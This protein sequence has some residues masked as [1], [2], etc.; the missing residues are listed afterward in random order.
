[1]LLQT[2]GDEYLIVLKGG[3]RFSRAAAKIL[4]WWSPFE[5]NSV[6]RLAREGRLPVFLCYEFY[7]F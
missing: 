6:A 1:M 2:K 5:R 4:H 3:K 7:R